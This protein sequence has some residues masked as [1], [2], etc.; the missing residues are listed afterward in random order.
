MHRSLR[1]LREGEVDV[2]VGLQA[3][4]CANAI[5]CHDSEETSVEA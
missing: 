1:L 4:S 3:V 5:R 2:H